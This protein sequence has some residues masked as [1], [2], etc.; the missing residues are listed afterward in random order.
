MK[1]EIENLRFAYNSS[2]LVLRDIKMQAFPGEI[3][4]LIGPNA[5]GKS[6]LLK[7]VAGILRPQGNIL[8]DGRGMNK[9]RRSDIAKHVSY[10]PQENSSRAVL[11]VFEAVLVGRLQSLSWRVGAA[12]LTGVLQALESLGIEEL[13][14]RFL[15]EL[16]GGQK[17]IVSIA[18]ALVREPKVLL[19]DEPASSLDLQ[20]ELETLDLIRHITGEKGITTVISL[21]ALNLVAR[22]ADRVVI[23]DD[24][25]VYACGEPEHVITSEMIRSVYGVNAIVRNDDGMLHIN[26][27]SSIRKKIPAK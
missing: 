6:T 2:D 27:V 3:T 1:I 16:S 11:T 26:P 25:E 8:L 4:A 5:A 21:H 19:L 18:Q 24:G 20:H 13:A 23:L 12:D 22:Y 17:Q 10:L 9:L 15:N 7:C 14:P